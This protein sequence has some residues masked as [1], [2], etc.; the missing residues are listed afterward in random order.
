MHHLDPSQMQ[1]VSLICL[2][3]CYVFCGFIFRCS[4]DVDVSNKKACSN[5]K[6][7]IYTPWNKQH[8]RVR[9]NF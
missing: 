4:H 6:F 2:S 3:D 1:P 8:S 9:I 7:Y 5:A